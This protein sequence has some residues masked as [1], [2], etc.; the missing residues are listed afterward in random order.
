MWQHPLGAAFFVFILYRFLHVNDTENT[1]GE[2]I[3]VCTF[4]AILNL[5]Y[6]IHR[7]PIL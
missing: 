3:I 6:Y 2:Y 1:V 7:K 5:R 4:D